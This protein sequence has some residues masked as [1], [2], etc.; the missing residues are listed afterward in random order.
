MADKTIE[1]DVLV[2]GGGLAGCFAAIKAA[3]K[4][5]NVVV[6]EKAH[7]DR[8]GNGTTGLHRIPLINP[9]YNFSYK[10][11]AEKNVAWAGGIADE[12]VSYAFAEETM[13][14]VL[15]LESWGLN[16]RK[17]DGQFLFKQA[18]DIA[19]GNIVIWPTEKSAWH[20]L[21]PIL[22]RK[23]KS[24]KNVK[25]FNRTSALSLLNKDGEVGN[26]VI[27][28]LA[29]RTR[30]GEFIT[31]KAKAVILTSGGSY[32]LGRNKDSL[33]APTRFVE[34]G[35]P[36]NAG[37]GHVMAFRAGA[38]LVNLEFAKYSNVWKDFSHWGG[39]PC[40][41]VCTPVDGNGESIKP[42]I[43]KSKNFSIY[44]KVFNGGYA[45]RGPLYYDASRVD[46]YPKEKGEMRDF[47]TALENESTYPAYALWMKE[48]EED[49]QKSPV[50]FET[51]PAYLHNN[52]GGIHMNAQGESSLKGLYVAGDVIGGS[53]RQSSAGAFVF[54][55]KAGT[56]A[57][58]FVK[59]QKRRD[60]INKYQVKMEKRRIRDPLSIS[61]DDGY[62]WID[63]ED[64]ARK[65]AT[66]YGPPFTNDA[67]LKR[68]L[69]HLERIKRRYLP[70]LYAS[71]PR[72]LMRVSEVKGIFDIVEMFLKGALF[73]KE[74]RHPMVS[75][76]YKT[77]HPEKDDGNWLKHTSYLYKNGKLKLG[78]KA[79]KKLK[80]A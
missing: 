45:S 80:R 46:G 21:K 60:G 32:R 51:H 71:T 25:V 59:R 22:A 61:A 24:F 38:R 34:C 4:G 74:S 30:T 47:L 35:A 52:Q 64:K 73:R 36:T 58:E 62:S 67:K 1:T 6:F 77:D 70:L 13:D 20:N 26:D 48:R 50:E 7:I 41:S 43:G 31:C 3:E 66:D 79:V 56:Y 40:F 44:K 23:V 8:S 29:L 57:A 2:L 33:Y 15:D 11:F 14:R 76:L 78:K 18:L 28:A 16:C 19:P 42:E 65:I 39:G 12:D 72:D 75:M 69:H 37:E 63:L 10:E 5:V 17:E 49:F 68:G 9:E 53:W 55:A 27:G 54:G